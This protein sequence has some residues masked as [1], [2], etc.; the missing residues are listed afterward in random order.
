MKF[1]W[2]YTSVN[3]IPIVKSN[4]KPRPL[5]TPTENRC[6]VEIIRLLIRK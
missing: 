2:R 1:G 3:G 5:P 6:M 4:W